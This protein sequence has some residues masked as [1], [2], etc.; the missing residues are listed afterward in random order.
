MVT[1]G[2]GLK[3]TDIDIMT[4]RELNPYLEAYNL[5]NKA[6]DKNRWE[7]GLYFHSAVISALDVC[8]NGKKATSKYV[9]K[10]FLQM[11]EDKSNDDENLKKAKLLFANLAVMQSNFNIEKEKQKATSE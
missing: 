1:Y 5:R 11:E 4:P 3:A 7:Q 2:Y 8:F 10:P 6:E 9:E